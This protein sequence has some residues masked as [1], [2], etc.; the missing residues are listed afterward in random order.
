[1][2]PKNPWCRL[3]ENERF[4]MPPKYRVGEKL[5]EGEYVWVRMKLTFYRTHDRQ[6]VVMPIRR[7]FKNSPPHDNLVSVNDLRPLRRRKKA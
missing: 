6:A 4:V 1:M 2:A 5:Q 7:F 3:K